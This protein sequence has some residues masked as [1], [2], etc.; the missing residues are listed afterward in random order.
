MNIALTTELDAVNLMLES[1]GETP[2]ST[3]DDTGLADVAIAIRT[4]KTTS[5]EV[6]TEGWHFN[7]E[8]DVECIPDGDGFIT[9]GQNI[10][11]ATP[12]YK[13]VNVALRGVRLYDLD[14]RTYVFTNSV[15]MDTVTFLTW[16]ELPDSARNYIAVKA[17]RK[18]A[19]K[20]FQSD[21]IVQGFTA[22]DEK[23]ARRI[24]DEYEGDTARYNMLKHSPAM[25]RD[26]GIPRR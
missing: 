24:L 11:R 5:R 25:L 2:V 15:Y 1:I 6:Q 4:L 13:D 17:A 7:Q 16:D 26:Y 10:L 9:F 23:D 20:V 12:T 3:L 8:S 22:E 18:F 21:T 14:N 19:A